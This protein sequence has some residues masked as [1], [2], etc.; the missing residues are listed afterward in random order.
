MM[1]PSAHIS[2]GTPQSSRRSTSGAMYPT[3]PSTCCSSGGGGPG[4]AEVADLEPAALLPDE[5]VP[6]LQVA[7]HDAVGVHGPDAGQQLRHRAAR[8]RLGEQDPA[9]ADHIVEARADVLQVEVGVI[10]HPGAAH[11][12]QEPHH[13]GV[14]AARREQRG[15]AQQKRRAA[16]VAAGFDGDHL[17]GADVS[18]PRFWDSKVKKFRSPPNWANFGKFGMNFS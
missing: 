14:P 11:D 8:L 1:H 5:H 17:A 2:T 12:L 3:V 13:A 6:G 16:A 18:R 9:A 15:L 7:V 10:V 4:E